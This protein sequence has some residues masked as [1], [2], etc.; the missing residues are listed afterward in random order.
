MR[1]ALLQAVAVAGVAVLRGAPAVVLVAAVV[2]VVASQVF[3]HRLAAGAGGLLGIPDMLA[4]MVHT[5]LPVAAV[6][7]GTPHGA[8]PGGQAVDGVLLAEPVEWAR[9]RYTEHPD[10][11][12]PAAML[13]TA[14][15][16]SLGCQ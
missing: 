11:V 16:I 13:Y 5:L 7:R 1:L 6:L 9:M 12:A 3:L 14:T 15:G 2:A 10:M 4:R 8:V